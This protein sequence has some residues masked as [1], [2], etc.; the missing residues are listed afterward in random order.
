MLASA[1]TSREEGDFPVR[2]AR[3]PASPDQVTG[4]RL[5]KARAGQGV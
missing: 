5:S 4:L 3:K 2:V 1:E